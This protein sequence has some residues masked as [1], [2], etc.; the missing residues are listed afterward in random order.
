MGNHPCHAGIYHVMERHPGVVVLHDYV[1]HH[2]LRYL[3]DVEG[4]LAAYL[5]GFPEGEGISLRRRLQAGVWSE[6]DGFAFPGIRHIV[7][8]NQAVIVH[9]ETAR[10]YVL[11][12]VPGARVHVVPHHIGADASPFQGLPP[13]EVKRRVGLRPDYL[14]VGSFGFASASKRLPA[15]LEAFRQFL[16]VHPAAHYLI[17]GA[18]D[19]S[20]SSPQLVRAMGLDGLVRVTGRVPWE[21]FYGLMDATDVGIQLRYPSAGE[22]SGS[23]LR[24]MSKGKPVLLTNYEQFSEF[25]DDCCLKVDL[26][27]AEV[28]TIVAYLRLLAEDPVLRQRIGENARRHVGVHNAMQRTIA[29]Y[30][31]AIKAVVGDG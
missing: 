23:I 24:V 27:P 11:R 12:Q 28:P 20:F 10:R 25:P 5:A 3:L 16:E 21:E 8:R 1:L 26:G 17:V 29:G 6:L 13:A 30:V 7:E 2:F 15:A 31:R 19:P 22:M 18:D 9:T 14:V 4:D